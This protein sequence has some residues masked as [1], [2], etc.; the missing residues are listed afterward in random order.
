MDK[1]VTHLN[2][3]KW[4]ID[5]Q[6]GKLILFPKSIGFA[7]YLAGLHSEIWQGIDTKQYLEDERNA[8]LRDDSL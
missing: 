5:K 2:A 8:W 1:Q 6:D 3:K 7:D 4:R